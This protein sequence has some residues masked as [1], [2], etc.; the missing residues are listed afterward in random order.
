MAAC[1]SCK[2]P[3]LVTD[4]VTGDTVCSSC[5]VVQDFDNYQ[6][7][8]GGVSGPEGTFVRMGTTGAGTNYS[9]KERKLYESNQ[10]IEDIT[11]RFSFSDTRIRE[12]R[13]MIDKVTDGEFG[14]GDWF[15]VLVGA[16]CYIVM[17]QINKPLPL[18]EVVAVV[19]C[20]LYEMGK[21]LSR[22]VAHLGLELKE[23]DLVSLLERTIRGFSGF[24]EIDKD[25][26]DLMVKQGNFVIQCAIKWFLTTG[27]RPGPVVVAVLV[28]IG[29]VNEI[30]V[31]IEDVAKEMNVA[32]RT[33]K[34]RYKELLEAMVEVAR[35]L[36][37]GKDVNVKNVVKNAHFVFKYMEMK[38]MEDCKFE[39]KNFVDKSGGFDF[40]GVVQECLSKEVGSEGID[41]GDSV[42]EN[43]L[44]CIDGA[45]EMENLQI[46]H[47]ELAAIYSKFKTEF[48]NRRPTEC[49]GSVDYGV[50]LDGLDAQVFDEWWIGRSELCEKLF[51]EQLL[52]KDVGLNALPPSYI[53]GCL[54]VE[55]RREKIRAAKIR[56]NNIM[57]PPTHIHSDAILHNALNAQ[58]CN[59]DNISIA[60]NVSRC[61]KRKK[62]HDIN[63]CKKR[64]KN[65]NNI[66]WED[67][68]IET[69]LLHG[70]EGEEIEKGYYKAL[71][72][73][74]VFKS[75]LI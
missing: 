30:R 13:T 55:R 22:V 23:F 59:N 6:H 5:G 35:R 41:S 40:D 29:L 42:A 57:N 9:Y 49:N 17:R 69:L 66:D 4:D 38:S 67:F 64:N 32:V 46:S 15:S 47:V 16:C 63:R 62:N 20:E 71:L 44:R 27:R 36:P 51:M 72:G 43:S 2:S 7:T 65:H 68:I 70:V 53:R 60:E 75:D 28:F 56:I 54:A 48:S 61:K 45:Q 11:F 37:W 14:I 34:I 26:I 10:I 39:K 21:M 12:V 31:C 50:G 19:G 73:L 1:K 52:E 3:A 18:S 74:Y 24:K 8:F 33:C 58:S 25:K